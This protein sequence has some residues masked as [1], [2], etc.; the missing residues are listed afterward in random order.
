MMNNLRDH[1][2]NSQSRVQRTSA[3]QFFVF[4]IQFPPKT[5]LSVELQVLLFNKALTKHM[6][7]ISIHIVVNIVSASFG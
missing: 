2:S 1:G 7:S 6:S 5:K 3:L 4:D